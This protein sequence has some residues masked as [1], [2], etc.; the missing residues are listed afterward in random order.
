MHHKSLIYI[1]LFVIALFASCD[2]IHEQD[3]F[4]PVAEETGTASILLVEFTGVGCVNCPNAAAEAHRLKSS[5][6][7]RLVVVEMHPSDNP[8]TAAKPEYDYT[9]AAADKYYRMYGGTA[10]TPLPTGVVNGA[11]YDG[12]FFTDFR[13]W[14][15]AI[16]EAAAVHTNVTLSLS[17]SHNGNDISVEINAA[18]SPDGAMLLVWLIEDSLIGPQLMPDGTTN[19]SYVHN[20]V[21]REEIYSGYAATDY[22]FDYTIPSRYNA[23]QCSIAAVLLDAQ[24]HVV[25]ATTEDRSDNQQSLDDTPLTVLVD[26]VGAIKADT[27]IVITEAK[28]NV[29][30]GKEEMEV[31]GLINYQGTLL[32]NIE[33][34][35]ADQDDQFCCA[36]RCINTNYELRQQL[37]FSV[38]GVSNWFAHYTPEHSGDAT[39]TYTFAPNN[40]NALR[41]T[42]VYRY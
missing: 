11:E 17:V 4:I 23:S 12:A 19:M 18:N 1:L 32:V 21:L 10:S 9:S 28:T 42:I 33:R 2:V 8:F 41:L 34:G 5:Y 37:S 15:S 29:I 24:G 25:A 6:G 20:H 30:T 35:D 38:N 31:T 13:L 26:G 22:T 36:D 16:A 3:R 7:N 40:V 14:G 39:V 27:T